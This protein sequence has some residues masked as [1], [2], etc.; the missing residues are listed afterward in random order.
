MA[1]SKEVAFVTACQVAESTRQAAYA[2]AFATYAPNGFGVFANLATYIAALVTA[3]SAYIDAVQSAATTNG[4]SASVKACL[5]P[6]VH[7]GPWASILT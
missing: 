5:Y 4:I 7:G 3:D 1:T 2:S 6:G